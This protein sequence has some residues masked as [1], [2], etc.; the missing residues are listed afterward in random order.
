MQA[1]E[2]VWEKEKDSDLIYCAGDLVDVGANPNEVIEWLI[3]HKAICIQGNH[4]ELLIHLMED[5]IDLHSMPSHEK[6]W[7]HYNAEV[8]KPENLAYLKT[9][10]LSVSFELDGHNYHMKHA[11]NEY[12][13]IQSKFDFA[14]FLAKENISASPRLI[15]G[16]THKQT[17][18]Y[19]SNSEIILNPGS[20]SYRTYLEPKNTCKKAEYITITNG[21]VELKGLDYDRSNLFQ[22]IATLEGRVNPSAHA[23]VLGRAQY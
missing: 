10:P 11:Y 7:L 23:K 19:F 15:F 1:L 5:N 9:L 6:N 18:A 13:V 4:D 22:H 12:L 14:E 20:T 3:E 8:I 21:Q 17:I 2:A 16:H